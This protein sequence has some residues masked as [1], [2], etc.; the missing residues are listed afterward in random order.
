MAV[1][2]PR[3]C[4]CRHGRAIPRRIATATTGRSVLRSR[5]LVRPPPLPPPLPPGNLTRGESQKPRFRTWTCCLPPRRRHRNRALRLLDARRRGRA[6]TRAPEASGDVGRQRR[7][8]QR[9]GSSAP[10]PPPP[11]PSN[12]SPAPPP[13]PPPLPGVQSAPLHQLSPSTVVSLPRRY[14]PKP[15]R[16]RRCFSGR[17]AAF[18]LFRFR[19]RRCCRH[20]LA[21]TARLRPVG[22]PRRRRPGGG[23]VGDAGDLGGGALEARRGRG[24]PVSASP[25]TACAGEA[26]IAEGGAAERPRLSAAPV[27]SSGCGRASSW[28][29]RSRPQEAEVLA[30]DRRPHWGRACPLATGICHSTS[31]SEAFPPVPFLSSSVAADAAIFLVVH[32][33]LPFFPPR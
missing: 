22:S 16:R 1:V 10:N 20:C 18:F 8:Q 3:R 13:P 12:P 25:A 33:Y 31:H 14:F 15:G 21:G 24:G 30:A 9:E 5:R 27:T 11:P 2:V 23:G 7:C 26:G 17:V 19:C 28:A 32:A 29:R 6:R 4:R